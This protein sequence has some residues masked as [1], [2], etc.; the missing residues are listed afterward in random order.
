MSDN[1]FLIYLL[2]LLRFTIGPVWEAAA[3]A[4]EPIVTVKAVVVEKASARKITVAV[5]SVAPASSAG[6][7]GASLSVSPCDG[8]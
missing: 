7:L 4:S 6:S 1:H 2:S 5:A 3:P 8:R